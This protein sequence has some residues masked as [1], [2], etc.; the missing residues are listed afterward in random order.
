M[1]KVKKNL[2]YLIIAVGIVFIWRGV[3]GLADIF[4]MPSIPVLSFSLSI[5]IG[6]LV[7]LVH[8]PNRLDLEELD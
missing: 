5:L 1:K 8:E 3:W 6:I 2:G 7:L 4:L